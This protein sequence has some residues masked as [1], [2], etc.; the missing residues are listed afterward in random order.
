MEEGNLHL[1]VHKGV[2]EKF[3][4][5][6]KTIKSIGISS[7][8]MR[9]RKTIAMDISQYPTH[10][11]IPLLQ[12]EG[13]K[14]LASTPIIFKDSILGVINIAYHKPHTFSQDE[15]NMFSSIGNEL[16]V[17]IENARLFKELEQH[18]KTIEALYSVG[19]VVSQSLDLN[20]I[21]KNAL[22]KI[23][24]IT[25]M[26]A[27]GIYLLENEELS[28]KTYTSSEFSEIFSMIKAE[29]VSRIAIETGESVMLN[30]KESN[31]LLKKG[32]CSVVS[33]PLVAKA[34]VIGVMI[35][36]NRRRCFFSQ[37]DL[38]LLAS[39]GSQMGVA[40]ENARLFNELEQH[41]RMLQTL[42]SIESLVSRSLNLEKIFEVALSKALEVTDADAGTLYSFDGEVLHL[43]TFKGLSSEFKEHAMIRKMGE[44]IPG[45]VAQSKKPVTM[46][47]SQFPSSFLRPYVE[48]EGLVSFIGTPLLSKGKMVGAMALGTKKKRI[49]TQDDLDL[50][51]SIGN[52]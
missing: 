15:L 4:K 24:E 5:A 31:L 13:L 35:F 18:N 38:E 37:H 27:G 7:E 46:D 10:E 49:F 41:H 47:I 34:K 9:L 52:V 20:I 26:D 3:A 8:A 11:L 19:M 32:I 22:S 25:G 21:F 42:Y 43:E 33:T 39:I 12:E 23:L 44:G 2:S 45:I 1:K 50:M 6:L 16:G 28:L 48:K 30:I 40:I 36:V 51:Y 14:S 17:A 29:Q